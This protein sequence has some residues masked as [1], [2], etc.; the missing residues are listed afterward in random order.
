MEIRFPNLNELLVLEIN[1]KKANIEVRERFS[2]PIDEI[3]ARFLA[4]RKESEELV[5]LSTCNRLSVYAF[6]VGYSKLLK[7][8]GISDDKD[9][10]RY[11]LFGRGKDVVLHLY[12]TAS[13]L[14]SQIL[15][16]NEILGQ[17]KRALSLADERGS[18]RVVLRE[19][20]TRAVRTGKR[21]RSET[22]ISKGNLSFSSLAIS[23][24]S[25]VL[26]RIDGKDI[27]LV[28]TG[29]IIK[30][31][32]KYFSGYSPNSVY[33]A[34]KSF[35]R[36][37]KF[38][39]QFSF[40]PISLKDIPMLTVH[41][42]ITATEMQD[43]VINLD[44]LPRFNNELLIIDL[45]FPRNVEKRVGELK[46]IVLYD[47]DDIKRM[48]EAVLKE[49]EREIGKAMEIVKEEAEKFL[50]WFRANSINPLI[51]LIR[52]KVEGIKRQELSWL[53]RKIANSGL[54]YDKVEQFA[55]RLIEKILHI[56]TVKLREL[57]IEEEKKVY[58]SP[59]EVAYN[60]FDVNPIKKQKR[61]II[62]GTRGSKLALIQTDE[63]ISLLRKKFSDEFEF[64]KKIVKTSGDR[65]NIGEI[66]AFVK[67]LELALLRKEVDIAIHSLKDM[68]TSLPDGLCIY[69]VPI[70]EDVRDILISR[71]GADIYE[72]T[73]NTVIGT[74]SPRR[75]AQLLKI[76]NDIEI[77]PIKGNVDTRLRKL[78]EGEYGAIILA[79]AGVKRLGILDNIQYSFLRIEDFLPAVSQ[80]A[81]AIEGRED[82]SLLRELFS[83]IDNEEYRATTLAERTFLHTIG[84]GCRTPV[85]A[86]SY[87][88]ENNALILDAIILSLDGKEYVRD[89]IKGRMDEA[90]KLGIEL[91][92]RLEEAGGYKILQE[93]KNFIEVMGVKK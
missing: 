5:V 84:G 47:L 41:L 16:E 7:L 75:I 67:E 53:K 59:V 65:G 50:K 27:L 52:K 31:V 20:F 66:G 77:K 57:A 4:E 85:G 8:F 91:A 74:G 15:G 25:D 12:R 86:Y 90:S 19:L 9:V 82:D 6:M 37:K 2:L 87:I 68:T 10:R 81:I 46:G 49:R 43:Y 21:V 80:G 36:A 93:V 54:S 22:E 28:G 13:G 72:L 45:G 69:A 24:A 76:R 44:N 39:E 70:R 78:E 23:I 34:S 35:E 17:V 71:D 14:E 29:E 30:S 42:V 89:S 73:P 18:I 55:N 62:V 79:Y 92:H 61:K 3:Y 48:S 51:K 1:H 64:E 26:G 11:L 60:V 32:A 63:V 38:A 58:S 33:V 40:S 56:P 88:D 83:K